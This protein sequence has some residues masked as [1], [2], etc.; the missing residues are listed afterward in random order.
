MPTGYQ[1]TQQDG[2]YYVTFQ[3]LDWVIIIANDAKQS[4]RIT[5]TQAQTTPNRDVKT[6]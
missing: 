3:V 4:F 5:R 6:I 1:I 2:M